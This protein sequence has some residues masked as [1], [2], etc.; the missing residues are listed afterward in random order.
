M[1]IN[2]SIIILMNEFLNYDGEVLRDMAMRLRKM[3]QLI[4]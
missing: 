3:N 4:D 1:I 2:D